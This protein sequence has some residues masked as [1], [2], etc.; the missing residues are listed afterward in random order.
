MR[1]Q[2]LRKCVA[3]VLLPAA[4]MLFSSPCH[5][6]APSPLPTALE[7]SGS[8]P[9]ASPAFPTVLEAIGSTPLLELPSLSRATGCLILAKGEHLNP[10]LS[11]KDRAASSII[12]GAQAAGALA[13]GSTV[14][15][16]TGGNTGIA[17]AFICAAKGL[18]LT[19]T[20]PDYVAK[21]KVLACEAMGARVILCPSEGVPFA[22]PR[23]FYQVAKR[24]GQQ[25][26]WVWG[27]QFEGLLNREAHVAGTGAEIRD[28]VLRRG[29]T[30]DA[31]VVSAG[32]GG[33]IAGCG[34]ALR[35]AFPA[36]KLLL[37]DPTGSSLAS[38]VRTGVLQASEGRGTTLEGI[39][40]GRLT[41]NM[42]SCPPLDG[43]FQGTDAE[44]VEMMLYLARHEGLFVGPSAALNV[45]GAV[46][47]ARAL[48]PGK[49]I[50]T[51]L[52]DSGAR[53]LSKHYNPAWREANGLP[54]LPTE[55]V[56]APS[57]RLEFVK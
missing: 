28:A 31:F 36:L 9:L 55:A 19:L 26:G 33:T 54:G 14:V 7:A 38:Y 41:A 16:A 3:A 21:E 17:L 49:V 56:T 22:D 46:K 29:L 1:P 15:E 43:A 6:E 52:C 53:Y 4:G 30:L 2:F 45:V 57:G 37:I 48:G 42:A 24:L 8:P 23:H 13:P 32:T 35:A 40:I 47:A 10:G 51:V 5:A 12:A 39:G 50:A 20:M 25:P 27:N 44:A 11:V 18:A 34:A